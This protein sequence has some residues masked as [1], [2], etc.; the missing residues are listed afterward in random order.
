MYKRQAREGAR[1]ATIHTNA[2]DEEIVQK[3]RDEAEYNS[4]DLSSVPINVIP[5]R[6][7]ELFDSSSPVKIV[8]SYD[9]TLLLGS[10][11]QMP[12]IP[13]TYSAVMEIPRRE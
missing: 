12:D 6:T 11:I 8:V 2:L 5:T 7:G 4:I 1:F 10:I 13:L 3:V 9:F